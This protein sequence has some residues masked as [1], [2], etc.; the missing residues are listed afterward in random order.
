MIVKGLESMKSE[1]EMAED[2]LIFEQIHRLSQKASDTPRLLTR[3]KRDKC[4]SVWAWN[5]GPSAD[6]VFN[7]GYRVS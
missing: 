6:W 5:D 2:D 7:D 1:N 4:G 3:S